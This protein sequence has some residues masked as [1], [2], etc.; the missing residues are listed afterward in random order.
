VL[1]VIAENSSQSD[2]PSVVSKSL[3]QVRLEM[4]DTFGRLAKAMGFARS[5]GEIYGLLYLSPAP[6]SAQ[7]IGEALSISKG[8]VS[9][10]TRQLITFGFVHKVWLQKERK[11]YF[12]AELELGD[13]ARAAYDNIFKVR[14][15]LADRSLTGMVETLGDDKP[16]MDPEEHALIEER[17]KRLVKMQR[18]AKQLM[19]LIERFIK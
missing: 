14:A 7:E 6:M 18:R 16:D 10:G 19:P 9:T 11:D 17:L 8:S 1:Q 3:P 2:S 12:V 15:Q 13:L 5:I 4:V